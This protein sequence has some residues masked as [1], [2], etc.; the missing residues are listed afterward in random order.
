MPNQQELWLTALMNKFL[1][2]I[3]T[4]LMVRLGMPPAD[5]VH[6]IPNYMAYELLVVVII[7]VGALI[8]R[9][10][11]S[12]ENPGVFQQAMESILEFTQGMADEMIGHDGRRYVAMIGTFG[13][14]V[15]VSN[16]IGLLPTFATPTASIQVTLGCA[17]VA[18]VYYNYHGFRQHGYLGYLKHLCGPMMAIAI[19]MFPIEVF[20]NMFRMLSLSVRL[21]ANMLVGDIL[22]G[23]F[24]GL[25]PIFVPA[26]FMALHVFVSVLQAYVFMILPAVYISMA[27][28]EEH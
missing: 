6:P 19:L 13:I 25:I 10:R 12:V 22:E 27:V 3:I 21:W 8:L 2:A 9:R 18:F 14:F 20:S 1:G 23:I 26:L 15:G 16:L 7:V 28:A 5:P 4:P 17:M 24:T 11:L